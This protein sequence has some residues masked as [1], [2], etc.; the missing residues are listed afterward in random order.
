MIAPALCRECFTAGAGGERCPNCGS[1]RIV[2]HPELFDLSMAHLDCDAFY[3]AIEKRDDPALADRPVIVGGGGRRG[4]VSTACY[5]A[6]LSGVG[7]AMPMFKARRL[8]PEAVILQPDMKRYAAVGREVRA[9]MRETTP[10]VEPLSLDEAFLDLSGTERLHGCSP[11]ETLARLVRRIEREI[12]ITASVGLSYNKFLAKLASDLDK[13][14][15]FTVLGRA[16]AVSFL[17]PRPVGD[18]WGVGKAL[19]SRLAA[20][21]ITTIGQLQTMD[22]AR[23]IARYGA[24]GRRLWRF[25]RG[26]DDRR[27]EPHAPVKS[28]SSETTFDHDL[29]DLGR[30]EAI[31]WRHCERVAK[32]LK[33]R[34][35]AGRAVTLK[36]KRA[37]FRLRTR[38]RRLADPTQLADTLFRAAAPLLADEADGTAFR[39]LGVAAGDLADPRDADPPDLLDPDNRRRARVEHAID[40]VRERFG[41]DAIAKGRSLGPSPRR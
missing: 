17:A 21:G 34:G 11:A 3:A 6:R 1:P 23:L 12:G 16:E 26:R 31:L 24:I 38:S 20:D 9:L 29:A 2:R 36:L 13:P 19:R 7:S 5:L 14:R 27:V 25:A 41:D 33:D 40:A 39:L 37:D 32:R 4:V 30:L 15:G 8:C 18:I 35:L 22:E 10:L 28:V